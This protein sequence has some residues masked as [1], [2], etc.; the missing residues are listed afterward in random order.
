M[1][2]AILANNSAVREAEK[3]AVAAILSNTTSAVD[4]DFTG[5][6][7]STPEYQ[8]IILAVLDLT[9]DGNDLDLI[10]LSDYLHTHKADYKEVT[11]N[12]QVLAQMAQ[13]KI[14]PNIRPMVQLIHSNKARVDL[15]KLADSLKAWSGDDADNP[16]DIVERTTTA[17]DRLRGLLGR[18]VVTYKHLSEITPFVQK[19]YDDFLQGVSHN[20]PTGIWEIDSV[21]M[22]GGAAGDLWVIGAPTGQGKSAFCL[23]LAR[24]QSGNGYPVLVIS[25]EMLDVENYK[26]IHSSVA[27]IP[28]YLI[29]PNMPESY[30]HRLTK[31]TAE[32]EQYA[33][34]I[35]SKAADIKSIRTSI[36]NAVEKDGVKAVYVDYLQL[37][38]G[39]KHNRADEVAEVSRALK[40]MAMDFQV[41]ICALGQYNRSAVLS[42]EIGNHSFSESSQ[43]EKDASI[44]LHLELEKI[45]K[46]ARIPTWRKASVYMGKARNAPP[47][48]LRLYFR[49]ETFTFQSEIP[50]DYY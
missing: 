22:G 50:N 24:H 32:V 4:C 8:K 10:Q 38:K 26:R 7:F 49:G 33:M 13:Y 37:I 29:K 9:K 2:D 17:L 39:T 21:T 19:Q 3:I 44:I 27:D 28:Y 48:D 36:K 20:I 31:T 18:D 47:L 40:E 15:A 45:E 23:A 41:W 34:Y 30:Y 11:P 5:L 1:H 16:L 12:P 46:G 42:G 25:R 43:I 14:P 35:D 6:E